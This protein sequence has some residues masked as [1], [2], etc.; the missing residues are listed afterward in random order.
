MRDE[1]VRWR[2]EHTT[3]T[4]YIVAISS[5]RQLIPSEENDNRNALFAGIRNGK[6]HHPLPTVSLRVH[7]MNLLH[8]DIPIPPL[9]GHR[10][11]ASLMEGD[12][13]FDRLRDL[14]VHTFGDNETTFGSKENTNEIVNVNAYRKLRITARTTP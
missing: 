13:D 8:L 14:L 2:R 9:E 10:L 6:K 4:N 1:L 3:Y 11:D 12:D 5:S 7:E